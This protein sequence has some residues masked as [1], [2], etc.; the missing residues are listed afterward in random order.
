MK[1]GCS[2]KL[3]CKHKALAPSCDAENIKFFLSETK[4]FISRV[5][6]LLSMEYRPSSQYRINP[7]H[8]M[9]SIRFGSSLLDLDL[10]LRLWEGISV[11]SSGIP[12]TSIGS[13][14]SLKSCAFALNVL[15]AKKVPSSLPW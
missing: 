3:K 15:S 13:F 7:S 5:V 4:G 10:F 6:W 14:V 8:G 11:S 12:V 9:I 2:I 1:C